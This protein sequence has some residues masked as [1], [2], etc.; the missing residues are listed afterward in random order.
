MLQKIL[1]GLAGLTFSL[2]SLASAPVVDQTLPP[3]SIPDRGELV[4]EDNEFRYSAWSSNQT[5]DRVHVIQYIA[6][7]LSGKKRFERFTDQLRDAVDPEQYHVT[8][9]LNLDAALWGTTGFVLSELKDNKRRYPDATMVLDEEGVGVQRWQ[10]GK[11]GAV[12]LILDAAGIVRY[13]GREA[14]S[15]EQAPQVV[16]LLRSLISD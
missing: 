4:L 6:A 7:S 2:F 11:E 1:V 3:L 10:L 8:T 5:P 15:S 14:I 16:E 12:L 9:I 13:V